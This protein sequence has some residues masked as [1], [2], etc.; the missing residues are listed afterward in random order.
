MI[1]AITFLSAGFLAWAHYATLGFKVGMGLT[2][3]TAWMLAV[4]IAAG[5]DCYRL[6]G[7]QLMQA[8]AVLAISW[9]A[10]MTTW[11]MSGNHLV[12]FTLKNL[13]V[14]AALLLIAFRP[15]TVLPALLHGVIILV[16]YLTSRGV[17][18]SSGQRPRVFL[19]WSHP[20]ISAGLQHASLLFM[21]GYT[22]A[23]NYLL[24]LRSGDRPL[25]VD[26]GSAR[27]ARVES[28]EAR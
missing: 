3:W 1:A 19:A 5:I 9:V 8:W 4:L 26:Y 12:D 23:R 24:G 25:A 16:A 15:E 6:R 7:R 28:K 21:G 17:I 18:P 14:M 2:V 11:A 20:D 27:V 22:L 10:A 13:A